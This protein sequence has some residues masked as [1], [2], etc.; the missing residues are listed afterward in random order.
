[1]P[2]IARC[3]QCG[4][5]KKCYSPKMPPTGKGKHKI[6]FI[7]E[8]PGETEDRQ[9]EQLIGKAGQCFRRILGKLKW[10]LDDCW[11]TNVVICRPPGNEM[12]SKYIECCRPNLLNTIRELQPK[13]IILL[14]KGAVDSVIGPYWRKDMGSLSRWVGWRI[15]MLEYN[16][17]VCPTYHPSYLLRMNED[18]LLE[19][20][21]R[22][23][24][25]EARGMEKKPRDY[26]TLE[27]LKSRIEIIQEEHPAKSRLRDLLHKKGRMAFDYETT[28]L[29]PERQEQHIVTCSF[30]FEGEDT[31]AINATPGTHRLLSK[32]LMSGDLKKIASNL[33]FEERWTRVKLGH[34]VTGWMWDTMLTAHLLDNRP[35]ITSVKFQAFIHLGISDYNS[36]IENF[37]SSKSSNELNRIHEI[38]RRDLLMYNG[39]DSLLEFQVYEVQKKIMDC[40]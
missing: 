27:Q 10:D 23:Q 31:F 19:L 38:D 18:E 5:Y 24:V 20:I 8:A 28:G 29:K 21:I 30:C 9:G 34:P 11:K 37:L 13:A 26:P 40:D 32:I 16:A 6:L 33:K 17:W 22:D 36:H 2:T 39:L 3:G 4:L 25:R 1:M 15:P 35:E 14:G 12:D 7:A